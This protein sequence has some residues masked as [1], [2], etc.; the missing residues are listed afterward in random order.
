[1]ETLQ[2]SGILVVYLSSFFSIT[3]RQSLERWQDISDLNDFGWRH[4]QGVICPKYADSNVQSGHYYQK[5]PRLATN[6]SN[7][8]ANRTVKRDVNANNSTW[9]AQTSVSVEGS[10]LR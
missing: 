9:N 3:W 7:V 5:H 8:D 1:M 2:G 4:E 10:V 6:W